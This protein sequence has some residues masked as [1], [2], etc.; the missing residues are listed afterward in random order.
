MART[1]GSRS[2]GGSTNTA[3]TVTIQ[4]RADTK[5]FVAGVTAAANSARN[6]AN[7]AA[8]ETAK[9]TANAAKAAQAEAAK[10]TAQS[11]SAAARE[12]GRAAAAAASTAARERVG[13]ISGMTRAEKAAYREAAEAAKASAGS[14]TGVM[15]N[16][17]RTA[18][19]GWRDYASAVKSSV[20]SAASVAGSA[21]KNSN[22]GSAVMYNSMTTGIRAAFSQAKDSVTGAFGAMADR[23]RS[24]VS[25]VKGYFS[26]LGNEARTLAKNILSNRDALDHVATGAGIGGA[27]LTAGFAYAVKQYADF[28]KAMSAVQA[29]THETAGNMEKLRTAAMKAGA[30]TKYSGSEAANGIEELAKAGVETKDILSG[31][32]DGALA[33]AAAGNIEVGEAAELAATAMTQFGLKGSDIGH[34]ADLLA[35]GAGKAQGSVGD[36]GYALKQSGL[37]AAQTGLSIEETTGTLAAFASAG[38]VGSDAGT[39]F[40]VMLQKLQNPSKEAAGL[41]NEYGISLYNAEGKFK[42]ITAV[43]GDLKRGLQNLTPA[44]RDAALATIFGSDAVRAANVLY[45]QGQEGIQGWID[46]TNDAGYAASTAAIQQNNLA[47]DIEKLGGAIDTIILSSSGG[48]SDFFRGLVQM[49][50]GLLDFMGKLPP[51]FLAVN[52]TVVGLTGVALLGVAAAAKFITA[53]QTMKATLASFSVSARTA[54]ASTR[55][56]AASTEG[57]AAAASGSKLGKLGATLGKIAGTAALAAEGIVLFVSA[58]NT[59]YKAPSLDSMNA[60]LKNTGGNLDQVNQKFKDMGGKATWAFLGLEDQVPKV[61]GLGEALVRLK[62]DAGDAMEGFSQ[63]VSHTAG[64]KV[65]ADA[66]KEAVSNL[67]E[68]LG[69][70]YAE[71][72]GEAEKF[73]QSIVRET[74]AASE[75]QGRAKYTA[76]EYMQ[77]FP[78][79]KEAVEN[80]ASSLN[81]SLTDEEKYQVMLG[82]YPPKLADATRAHDELKHSLEVQKNSLDEGSAAMQGLS[83]EAQEMAKWVEGAGSAVEDL[84]KG[85]KMLAG[86]FADSTKSMADYYKSMDDLSEAI[87]KNSAAYDGQTKTFDQT[88]KA[89]QKLNDAFAKMA[90]EG[91]QASSAVA[92]QG[93][94]YD[95]VRNHIHGVIDTLR[96]SALQMGLTSDEAEQL[97]HSI[98]AIPDRVSIDTWADTTAA[99]VMT[100][101]NNDIER[102]PREVTIGTQVFGVDAATGKLK[103]LREVGDATN[104]NVNINAHADTGQASSAL[105]DL[106]NNAWSVPGSVHTNAS[107]NTG[108]AFGQLGA[109]ANKANSVPGR[110]DTTANARTGVADS[111]INNYK[112]NL[113]SIPRQKTTTITQIFERKM[114][115][116]VKKTLDRRNR[117]W[118][119]HG[120]AVPGFASGGLI[121]GREPLS[122]WTDNVPAV[123]DAGSPLMVRS[124]EFIVNADATRKHR[125]LLERINSGDF[126]RGFS[127]GGHVSGRREFVAP[128]QS[129]DLYNQIVEALANWRP[130]VNIDGRTFYGT[131]R[132]TTLQARR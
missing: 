78:K 100:S 30:D 19:V 49:A 91:I 64:A 45:T 16:A 73:F 86:G 33:L 23:G 13:V 11:A 31:G 15:Q 10:G 75:A 22:F 46:K 27:A 80:Y 17:S 77:A 67:D 56:L 71:N 55:E 130:M 40:K 25:S 124:G 57:A 116:S 66:L 12:A 59:E 118:F 105:N 122:R 87:Q 115:D 119:A 4:L 63:W 81:V 60:A 7:Q 74:D 120:G 79:L 93:G 88:T 69:S 110:V 89:G 50:T 61:N 117:R 54:S 44:Q 114:V 108:Q 95:A 123:T 21:F 125:G 111:N 41:M 62:A 127:A 76:Q 37:V 47:G 101:L 24:M 5:N 8:R 53:Y 28:D 65:G 43:A 104:G 112:S 131:M 113:D 42:G 2:R 92:R 36:L 20:S 102:M 29:A 48:L 68:S 72:R 129:P 38:L 96:Q 18:S 99:R 121:P 126:V 70:L 109:L 90:Q 82:E 32:L 51:S 35:A 107:A 14:I 52:L 128:A 94:D 58:A 6:A 132:S 3:Q 9:A 97:I 39:S 34:V 98:Y 103:Y 106:I 85:L 26:D 1:G 84:D 83:G